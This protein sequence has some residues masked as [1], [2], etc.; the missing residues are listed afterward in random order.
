TVTTT[1]VVAV[2]P[3]AEPPT[4]S[5]PATLTLNENVTGVAIAGV[6][7]GPLAEDNDDTVS[8]TLTVSHGTLHVASLIG[9]T[10]TGADSATL[11]LSG[12]AAAVNTLLAGLTYTPSAE[13]EGTDTLHLSVTSSDGSNTYPSPATASTA[14]TVNPVAE[15]P[16]ASAP[17]TLTLN[18]NVTGVAI[19]GVSVGPLAED[20]NDTV[21][22][23]LTV[24][25]G[26]LHVASLT[27]VTVT[28]ADSATLTL[29]GNAAAV[30]TLLAGLTY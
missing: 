14:I 22:A 13:Y 29:S 6:S 25:H 4:A 8:A 12:N 9:V 3:V 21:S 7:V 17:A 5:A 19:A 1:E 24:S 18:E 2:A 26:T 10:V 15:P 11:T 30:N 28:G 20:N 27:G 16:T 23:T